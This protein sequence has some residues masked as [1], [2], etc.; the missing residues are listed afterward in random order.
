[1]FRAFLLLLMMAVLSVGSIAVA[2]DADTPTKGQLEKLPPAIQKKD[3]ISKEVATAIF[4]QC[5]SFYPRRFTPSA[6]DTYCDCSM[7][8]TQLALTSQENVDLQDK[9]NQVITNPVYQKYVTYVVAPCMDMATQDIEYLGCALD[10]FADSRVANL[11]RYCQCV[12]REARDHVTEFG[13]VDIMITMKTNPRVTDPFEA[14][15]MND[16]YMQSVRNA[17]DKCLLTYMKKPMV[18]N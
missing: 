5:R 14:L 15:W 10:R 12:G 9:K 6:L 16:K 8:A 7:T 2:Q 3:M 17:K 13:D 11:P 4:K 1:M 18:Y